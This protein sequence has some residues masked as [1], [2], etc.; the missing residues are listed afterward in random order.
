MSANNT[1][2]AVFLGSKSGARRAAWDGLSP[3][4]RQGKE[5]GRHRGLASLGREA[6]RR[7]R[8]PRWPPG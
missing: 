1:Y 8:H 4:S 7:H 5:K 3:S 6:S 2:L